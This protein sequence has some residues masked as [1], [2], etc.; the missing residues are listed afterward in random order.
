MTSH[1]R[2]RRT[3]IAA[4][5]FPSPIE[6]G[7]IVTNTAN[8]QLAVGDAASGSLGVPKP[9]IAVRYYDDLAQYI[10]NDVCVGP[11]GGDLMFLKVAGKLPGP[12]NYDDWEHFATQSNTQVLIDGV[13]AAFQD[14]DQG[15]AESIDYLNTLKVN[16]AGDTMTGPLTLPLAAPATNAQAANKKYVDDAVAAATGGGGSTASGIINVPA[17]GISA[18]NVQDA[19]NELDNE[20]VS[21]SG[22]PAFVATPSAPPPPAND[23]STKLINSQWY[24]G[25]ASSAAPAMDGAA[26]PGTSLMFARGDHVHPIDTSRAPL[27]SP[28]FSGVPTGP[29]AAV[30]TNTTQLATCAFVLAQPVNN[31]ANGIVTFIK[32]ASS[33]IATTAEFLANAANK[34][35]TADRVWAAAV[36]VTLADSATVTPD[37]N[38]GIDFVWTLGAAGRTLANPTNAKLGQKGM[39]YLVQDA[40]GGRTITTWGT[41]YKFSGGLKPTLSSAGNTVDV[42]SY[43]V[44]SATEIE[45]FFAEGMA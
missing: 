13:I 8:R 3:S 35:L 24:A 41:N 4:T 34:I 45:C 12:F 30:D 22:T 15:L 5:P 27:N 43:A 6:P 38:T 1:Y 10:Q 16:K 28:A 42:L 39:I 20:K 36:P 37:L 32:M 26:A 2:H 23:N 14:A 21:A 18:T 11:F 33:A 44:K 25:Q 19:L 9:L 40:I 31:I 7:E 17:G 29:T